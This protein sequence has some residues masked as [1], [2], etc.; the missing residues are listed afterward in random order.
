[1]PSLRRAIN[2]ANTIEYGKIL[3]IGRCRFHSVF[4][5]ESAGAFPPV[6]VC[7]VTP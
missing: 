2:S 3:M 6:V 1:M 7:S 4:L 5:D